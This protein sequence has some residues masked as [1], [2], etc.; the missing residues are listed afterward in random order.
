[1]DWEKEGEFIKPVH[2]CGEDDGYVDSLKISVRKDVPEGE[3]TSWHS[4]QGK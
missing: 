3:R 1:M 4:L 2:K